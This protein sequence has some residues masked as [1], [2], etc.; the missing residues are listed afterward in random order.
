MGFNVHHSL[1]NSKLEVI[2][3]N[4]NLCLKLNLE[5]RKVKNMENRS[6]S[7]VVSEIIASIDELVSLSR[8]SETEKEMFIEL[9]LV[10]ERIPPVFCDLRDDYKVM[11]TPLIRK[12]VES[13]EKE[14]VRAKCL[15]KVRNE[16]R[17]HVEAIAHDLGRSL[18]LVLFA[19]VE[20]STQFKMKI[21]ELHKELM[22]M[23]FNE[24]CSPTSTLTSTWT[25]TS[26]RTTEFVCDLRVEEIEEERIS[27]NVCDIALHLKYGNDDEFKLAVVGLKE[28]MQSKNVDDGW[29]NEEGIVLILLKRLGSN[30]S[31]DQSIIIQVLRYL[32]WNSPASK[33]MMADMGPLSTLVKSLAG[34]EE[35]RREAVGLLLDLCD[36]VN[37]RR[38]LGR[39]QGCIV[40]LVA[41]LKGDDPIASYDARKLLDV[42]SGNTQNV[43]YMAEADYF[44]PMVQ[45]LKEGSDMNKILMATGLSRM[46][47]TEQSR[48]SL[49][50]EGA[51]E[52]L[53]QMFRT[54]KLEAKLSALNAL[55]SLSGLKENVQRLINSGI[56][57]S[58]LQLLFSVTSVLMTLRE[59]A[60]AILARIAESEL[61][62][63]NHDMALQMLS[64]LNL[65]SPV[66]QN[67]LLQAL[68][69]IAAH[70]SGLEVR[71]K[72]VESGA[73]QLLCPFLMEN[74]TK[75]KNGALKLLYSLSKDAPEELEESHISVI[76]SI[77]PSTNCESERVFA[78][79]ILS[80]VPVTQ[81]KITDML[82]KANLVPILI[83]IMNTSLANS[84]I[85]TS[86][87]SESVA[88][89]LVRFTN[90]FDR[91]LQLHSA[92]QGVIP[93]LVKLLSSASTIAQKNAATSL[94]QL[95][96][97]SLSLSKAK[98]SRW[99]CVPPSKDS[100]CEVHGRQCFTKSTFCLVKANAIPPMIQIL[101]GEER[102]VDEAV[103]GALT[104]L[105]ED[106][107]C[108]NGS[109]YIVKMSGV[110][111][112]LK[113][114][115]SCHIGAQQ[116]ALW[117]LER[118]FRIEEHRIKY[119]ET[120]WSVLVDL[121]HKGDSSLKPAIAKLL[122][123]L[124]LFQFQD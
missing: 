74:N 37:V 34:E 52:P 11:D 50:E 46:V 77:I 10:L 90:P 22:N 110:Q 5:M 13:L 118:I 64:L 87:L 69:S 40:M 120:T 116:K 55:H 2:D 94:A 83:S 27:I 3:A 1:Y 76:L 35:E 42:L 6:F 82:R 113:A 121:A 123:R 102:D 72:M 41:I 25:S 122:V 26:S 57:N 4:Y 7:E 15:I 18:G 53:V 29:L 106:E 20:V 17:R 96:Q 30:K 12:A 21:G 92:E 61:I 107:I 79:G 112:I 19:T 109:K 103:L 71:K 45:L 59:P 14:I 73:I 111:G 101:E 117:I 62:L 60:A 33:E 48:A 49:G 104:T 9:A 99:L 68:N 67:Y 58:L 88:A 70:P 44:K 56:V 63:V 97:N 80:N 105:L 108:D 119:G 86:F 66:I 89:L 115:G 100:L 16:K 84:D 47:Q 32:V 98:S 38:R 23:K 114:L 91:K 8:N 65:S 24:S 78:V 81:K 36:L 28:L 43:L 85:S 51:I 39:V 93:L 75:I 95:S 54:E 124:E 31:V